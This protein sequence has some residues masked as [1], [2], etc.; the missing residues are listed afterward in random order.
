MNPVSFATTT[1]AEE[2]PM[3]R[4]WKDIVMKPFVRLLRAVGSWFD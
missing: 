3:K 2:R 4:T 1:V